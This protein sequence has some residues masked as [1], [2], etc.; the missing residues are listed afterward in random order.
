M[1][2]SSAFETNFQCD[3]WQAK[4]DLAMPFLQHIKRAQYCKVKLVII[5]KINFICLKSCLEEENIIVYHFKMINEKNKV[6]ILS[7]RI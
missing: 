3:L 5:E 7:T 1:C 2:P 4:Q 6:S